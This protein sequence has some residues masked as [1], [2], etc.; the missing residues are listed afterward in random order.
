MAGNHIH[1]GRERLEAAFPQ[2]KTAARQCNEDN[3]RL[4]LFVYAIE[5]GLNA[6]LMRFRKIFHTSKIAEE[7]YCG[8]DLDQLITLVR[9]ESGIRSAIPSFKATCPKNETIHP[10]RLHS[11]FRYGGSLTA[12]DRAKVTASLESLVEEIEENI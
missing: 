3:S 1:V 9:R 5:C 12:A 6:M 7:D 10:I 11:F 2:P 8:H 4:L